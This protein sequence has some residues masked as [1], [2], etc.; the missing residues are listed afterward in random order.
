[1]RGTTN[2]RKRRM[3]NTNLGN[4]S[5]FSVIRRCYLPLQVLVRIREL[6]HVAVK[7]HRHIGNDES[8]ETTNNCQRN[9][10]SLLSS[11]RRFVFIRRSLLLSYVNRRR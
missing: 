11:I 2:Q 4:A 1:M 7:D 8:T 9:R 10:K 6:N 5:G 3:K